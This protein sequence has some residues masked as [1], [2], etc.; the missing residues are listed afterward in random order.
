MAM[1]NGGFL[2]TPVSELL[3]VAWEV[4]PVPPMGEEQ[5]P[6]LA[7]KAAFL[8]PDNLNWFQVEVVNEDGK[9][10]AATTLQ[11]IQIA[12]DRDIP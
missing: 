12:N 2:V 4:P 7:E 9:T 5:E 11:R 3:E 1:M 8:D 6:S 10:G